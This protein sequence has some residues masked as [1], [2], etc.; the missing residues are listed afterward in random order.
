MK[1]KIEYIPV[2]ISLL[3]L[4]LTVCVCLEVARKVIKME[5]FGRR[6]HL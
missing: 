2:P 4:A 1:K 3:G 6:N 5:N